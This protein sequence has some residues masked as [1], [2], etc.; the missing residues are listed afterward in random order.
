[1]SKLQTDK[2]RVAAAKHPI[3][4]P[5]KPPKPK[6]CPVCKGKGWVSTTGYHMDDFPCAACQGSGK[7][8]KTEE[9]LDEVIRQHIA[10]L[11]GTLNGRRLYLTGAGE[12]TLIDPKG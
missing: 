10:R 5:K 3:K 12:V 8:G 2:K 9:Q 6:R 4:R 1:M 11:N 7:I